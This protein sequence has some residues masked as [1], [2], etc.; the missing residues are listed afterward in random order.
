MSTNI[1]NIAIVINLLIF[2]LSIFWINKSNFDIEPITVFLGQLLS[3]I[4]LI[5]G[6]T[7]QSKFSIKKVFN[8]TVDIDTSKKDTSDFDISDIKNNSKVKIKKR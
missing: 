1:K 4:V 8:S 7:I 3:L 5:F 6:D 2:I